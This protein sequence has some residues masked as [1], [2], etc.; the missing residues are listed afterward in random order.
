M[1]SVLLYY[2]YL[3][4]EILLKSRAVTEIILNKG[5]PLHKLI[6]S[7]EALTFSMY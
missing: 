7:V 2:V 4:K 6:F 5:Y 3:F 1:M